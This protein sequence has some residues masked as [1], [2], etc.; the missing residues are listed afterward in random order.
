VSNFLGFHRLKKR[1]LRR[2][3]VEYLTTLPSGSQIFASE[4]VMYVMMYVMCA[5]R[6]DR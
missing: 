5:G 2:T 6:T 1:V 4:C 3:S